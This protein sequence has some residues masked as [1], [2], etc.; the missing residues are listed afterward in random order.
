MD[1]PRAIG[2]MGP[3]PRPGGRPGPWESS[4]ATACRTCGCWRR[5]SAASRSSRCDQ[6]E[7]RRVLP[8]PLLAEDVR[9]AGVRDLPHARHLH[10][11]VVVVGADP[12][13]ALLRRVEEIVVERPRAARRRGARELDL[14]MMAVVD[15]DRPRL[16]P[17][18]LAEEAQDG[19][20]AREAVAP[21]A[22]VGGR[23]VREAAGELVPELQIEATPVAVLE[24]LDRRDVLQPLD[25][26]S[27]VHGFPPCER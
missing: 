9:V 5:T 22:V 8:A 17:E 19:F 23:L 20:R 13:R 2:L 3:P 18:R 14:G 21:F 15:G 10:V 11:L 7:A 26:R 24:A 12:H 1:L 4:A 6:P 16:P 27:E 25:A